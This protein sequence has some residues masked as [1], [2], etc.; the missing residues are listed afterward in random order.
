MPV[1]RRGQVTHVKMA[2]TPSLDALK[3]YS[4]GW[5]VNYT[6]GEAAAVP[7]YKQ[8]VEEDPQ[9][10]MAYAAL[11]LMYGVTGQ[12]ELARREHQQGVSATQ[13]RQ[14]S[15]EVLHHRNL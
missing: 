9:F 6:R 10:A 7:F 11:G 15:G 4:T 5:K 8:A 2:T 12:S 1:V 3:A 13:S 14:R